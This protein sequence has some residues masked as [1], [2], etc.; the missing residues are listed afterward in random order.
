MPAA[1]LNPGQFAVLDSA[2]T[3]FRP[4]QNDK[5]FLF[6]SNKTVLVD[7]APVKNQLRGRSPDGLGRWMRPTAASFGASNVFVINRDIVINEIM[8]EAAPSYPWE[9]TWARM[10]NGSS[11]SIAARTR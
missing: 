1:T 7:A 3:G 9:F 5:L 6:T 4:A 11:C 8:Y 10:R 2:Q